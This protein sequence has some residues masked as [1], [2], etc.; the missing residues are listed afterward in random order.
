MPAQH[1]DKTDLKILATLQRDGRLSNVEL[2]E[3][4]ALSP[5]LAYAD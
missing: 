4:V 5:L 2:A 3:T 1:F